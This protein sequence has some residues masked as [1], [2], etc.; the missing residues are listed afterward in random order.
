MFHL[1]RC[2]KGYHIRRASRQF[3]LLYSNPWFQPRTAAAKSRGD[4]VRQQ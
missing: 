1:P 3:E 2:V 4:R